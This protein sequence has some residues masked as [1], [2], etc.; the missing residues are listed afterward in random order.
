[1]SGVS[2]QST[3]AKSASPSERFQELAASVD[4]SILICSMSARIALIGESMGKFDPNRSAE[5][6]SCTEKEKSKL[7]AKYT[8]FKPAIKDNKDAI[9]ALNDYVATALSIFDDLQPRTGEKNEQRYGYRIDAAQSELT[10]KANVVKLQ[11][12]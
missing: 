12:L 7:Q 10:K 1:M 3:D 8:E 9:A 6:K 2:A 5:Q 11:L 4:G